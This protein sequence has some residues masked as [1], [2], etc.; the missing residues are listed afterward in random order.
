MSAVTVELPDAL[1]KKLEELAT[2]EGFSLEQFLASAAAEKLSAM[3]QAE[4]LEREAGLGTRE[5]FEKVLAA[6][7]DVEPE[8]PDDM[9]E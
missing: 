5:G 7:P 4:F 3:L 1:Y 8:N 2:R 6:V 9:V